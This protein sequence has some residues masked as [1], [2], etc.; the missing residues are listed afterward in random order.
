[1]TALMSISEVALALNLPPRAV[2]VLVE[3]GT[4]PGRAVILGSMELA[5][6]RAVFTAWWASRYSPE[7]A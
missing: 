1:M 6:D 4:I 7:A 5:V 3:A 2:V